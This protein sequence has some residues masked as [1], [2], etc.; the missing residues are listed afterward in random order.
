MLEP[1]DNLPSQ[2]PDPNDTGE[3][4]KKPI[5]IAPMLEFLRSSQD[6]SVIV[7]S[8]L[9][10]REN[11][12]ELNK[13]SAESVSIQETYES[14]RAGELWEKVRTLPSGL[15]DSLILPTGIQVYGSTRELF[16]SI[17]DL[18]RHHVPLA[19]RDCSL[20]AYWSIA[21]WFLDSLP[22]LPT[23]V[24]T[25]SARAADR[26]LRT[27]AAICRRP[28]A[29]A[30][31]N[32]ATLLNL[33]LVL[34]PTL[35]I[36]KPQLNHRLAALLDASNR[37][38]YLACT[39][40]NYHELYCAKCIYVGEQC[41]QPLMP[42]GVHIHVEGKSRRVLLPL[43]GE[44][45]IEEFQRKLL[46]YRF[47]WRESV[48]TSKFRVP[49]AEFGPEVGDIAQALGSA[50]VSEG[51]LQRGILELL[52]E[53]EEQS[54]VD[55]ASSMNGVVLR[56][57]LS[58]CHQA[59][60]EKV[61]VRDIAAAATEIWREEGESLRISSETAGHVLKNLGLYTR[62]LSSAGKGFAFNKPTQFLV[63]RLAYAYDV[64]SSETSCEYCHNF[65]TSHTQ[66]V[67]QKV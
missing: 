41:R 17:V 11:P 52:Q 51:D 60:V 31:V 35:L 2:T 20:V 50:L 33:P 25:G 18:L 21:T 56:A 55:R 27:L 45:L 63:H 39:S 34:K 13:I 58:Y 30:D 64:I 3:R 12:V 24:V 57:L 6:S 22:Y 15:S 48:A 29:L 37:P 28:W 66:D 36:C 53:N 19:E 8:L 47:V 40:K 14:E 43:V 7:Q 4:L 9:S 67:V 10:L 26:L 54:R 46:F 44:S 38:G 16:D 1:N 32:S 42:N 62:R 61:F 59:N 49:E 23:L 5:H 65:Q